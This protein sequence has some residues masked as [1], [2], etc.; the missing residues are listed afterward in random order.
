V[1]LRFL[2]DTNILSEPLKAAPDA[3]VME[4]LKKH[5]REICTA[6]LVWH[7]LLYGAARLPD[8]A[9]KRMIERFLEDVIAPTLPILPYDGSAAAWHASERARLERK[10]K[11]PPFVDG[12]IASVAAA[13]GLVLVTHNLADYRGFEGL[14]ITSWR[15]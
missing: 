9:R 12:M 11:T 5:E 13:H 10:G 14:E 1:T 7:E 15:S 6:T 8:G 4:N 3:R 2:L